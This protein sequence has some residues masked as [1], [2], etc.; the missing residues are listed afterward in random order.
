MPHCCQLIRLTHFGPIPVPHARAIQHLPLRAPVGLA[1]V[2]TANLPRSCGPTRATGIGILAHVEVA[3]ADSQNGDSCRRVVVWR[4]SGGP[5]RARVGMS[6]AKARAL[7]M[8]SKQIWSEYLAAPI[9]TPSELRSSCER[10]AWLPNSLPE[11]PGGRS[12]TP[13]RSSALDRMRANAR[14]A[15]VESPAWRRE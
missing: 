5:E 10:E 7:T 14:Q 3:G 12:A 15:D 4:T 13:R 8:G 11:G 1:A 9:Q 6:A 2:V